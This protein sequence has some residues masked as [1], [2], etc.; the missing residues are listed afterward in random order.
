MPAHRF[1]KSVH[2]IVIERGWLRLRARWGDNIYLEYKKGIDAG[3]YDEHDAIQK[4]ALSFNLH[5][6]LSHVPLIALW[7][8]G[9]G[10]RYFAMR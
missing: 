1:L 4:C 5:Q 2:N 9:Y 7:L 6:E 8:G 3:V 10:L